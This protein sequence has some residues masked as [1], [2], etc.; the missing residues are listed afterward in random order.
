MND[1]L[2]RQSLVVSGIPLKNKARGEQLLAGNEVLWQTD[3]SVW[4]QKSSD[5]SGKKEMNSRGQSKE[6]LPMDSQNHQGL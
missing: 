4:R 2:I 1:S 5:W 3:G 6:K